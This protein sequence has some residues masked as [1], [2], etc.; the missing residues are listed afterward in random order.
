MEHTPSPHFTWKGTYCPDFCQFGAQNVRKLTKISQK[1]G[2]LVAFFSFL[3]SPVACWV[4]IMIIQN[5]GLS[6][7]RMELLVKELPFAACHCIKTFNHHWCIHDGVGVVISRFIAFIIFVT[8]SFPAKIILIT[9]TIGIFIFNFCFGT[10]VTVLMKITNDND[11]ELRLLNTYMAW[12][13][14][15]SLVWVRA[16]VSPPLHKT[17][18]ELGRHNAIFRTCFDLFA[19]SFLFVW[20]SSNFT[21]NLDIIGSVWNP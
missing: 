8:I 13:F 18:N 1:V 14:L 19:I 15:Q 12:A 17:H 6:Q 20:W 10:C 7:T 4:A 9:W 11:T 21:S 3:S 16:I 2:K 5:L